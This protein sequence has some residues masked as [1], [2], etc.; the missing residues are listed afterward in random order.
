M[1]RT[2]KIT[3][4]IGAILALWVG[5]CTANF[6][7]GKTNT[8]KQHQETRQR[9]SSFKA[10]YPQGRSLQDAIKDKMNGVTYDK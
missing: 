2:D 10:K 4:V 6:Q 9:K 7:V 5:G 8:F 3:V 1:S